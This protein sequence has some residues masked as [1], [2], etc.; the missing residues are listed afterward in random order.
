MGRTDEAQ[1]WAMRAI[2]MAVAS[3]RKKYEAIGRINLGRALTAAGQGHEA[4]GEVRRAVAAADAI[5]SPFIRWQALAALGG[6]LAASGADPSGPFWRR[7]PS[8]FQSQRGYRHRTRRRFS[9]I[10]ASPKYSKPLVE[11]RHVTGQ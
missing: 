11:P 3:S 10:T 5:G 8:S 2:D 6:A 7:P 9:P 4:V 1:I